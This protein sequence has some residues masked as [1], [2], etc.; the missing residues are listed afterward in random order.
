[1]WLL[2]GERRG[3]FLAKDGRIVGV[4]QADATHPGVEMRL[5]F[6]LSDGASMDV[7]KPAGLQ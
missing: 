2:T 5:M 1:M 3:A 7:C 6:W 4:Y